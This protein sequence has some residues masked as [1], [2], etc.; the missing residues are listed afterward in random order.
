MFNHVVV[1]TGVPVNSVLSESAQTLRSASGVLTPFQLPEA[2]PGETLDGL[3]AFAATERADLLVVGGNGHRLARRAA[4]LAPCSV[5]VV[6]D[7]AT[8][9]LG[10]ILV[11]VDFSKASASA[12]R[13]ASQIAKAAGSEVTVVAV[14]SDE[15]PWLDWKDYPEQQQSKLEQFIE[16]TLG[17]AHDFQALIEPEHSLDPNTN[18]GSGGFDSFEGS[19]TAASIVAVADRLGSTL[20]VAG[21]RGRTQAAAVLLGSVVEKVIQYSRVP[22]L[23]VKRDGDHL[24][25]VEALLG[26]LL[27]DRQLVA[28]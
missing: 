1:A 27:D 2:A 26:K 6:P 11:P 13:E 23:T 15:D 5:L 7:G 12:L 16:E 4:M 8:V 21:T 17:P 24:S 14:E 22:V 25:L 19:R 10:R 3:L 9:T 28:S 18:I 20:I